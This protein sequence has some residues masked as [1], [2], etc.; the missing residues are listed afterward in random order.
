MAKPYKEI[1]PGIY[2]LQVPIPNNPLA[3]VLPYLIE[4]DDGYMLVDSG[5]NAPEAYG[6]LMAQLHALGV[7]LKELR[8]VVFTHVHPDHYGLAGRLKGDCDAEL[9]LGAPERGFIDSRYRRPEGLLERMKEWLASHGV[10]DHEIESLTSASM[11]VRGFVV[12]ADPDTLLHGGETLQSGKFAWEVIWT[13]GHSPGHMCFY[14][15]KQKIMITGDHIL[16]TIS[17]NVSL[18]PEASGNPLH[19]YITSLRKIK[20]YDVEVA[21]PAHEYDFIDLNERIRELEEHHVER[22]EE[23]LSGM[24]G[25]ARTGYEVAG[26]VKWVTG[27]FDSFSP[28]MRRAAMSETL[29][30]LEHMVMEGIVERQFEHG[31]Q[32]YKPVRTG[33]R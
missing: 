24:S 13:P 26:Y 9:M 23:M 30:H 2:Q 11:P 17:P 8:R 31:K 18:N 4:G 33:V 10:P 19:E 12:P 15:R 27:S 6:A 5:W 25:E 1:V 20:E 7:P 21:L 32:K 14:D 29:A 28:W 22:M 16:P 3:Y